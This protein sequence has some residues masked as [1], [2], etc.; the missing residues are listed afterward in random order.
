MFT[1]DGPLPEPQVRMAED[2]RAVLAERS[3]TIKGPAYFMYRDL[4]RSDEDHDWLRNQNLRYD[5][6]VIPSLDLCGEYVKT[7][8]H[9][10]PDNPQGTGY[11][12]IYEILEG[13]AEY[14]L[15][16]K[17]L[18]DAVVVTA[19]KGDVV[20]IPP[21]YGH[22]TINPGIA[23]L[24]MANIV[25]TAFESIY[26]DYEN[27]QGAVYYRME[28]QGY[29]ENARY[30]VHPQL[31]HIR[32]CNVTGFPGIRNRPLYSVIGEENTL[33][34]LNCPEQFRFGDVLTG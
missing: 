4:A 5:V 19:G 13:S 9:Y 2:L 16:D 23:T 34:F 7:K 24:V 18:S 10:H 15:Q 32:K 28:R 14:L 6:T 22:V 12:E 3:C 27:L 33:R 29:V 26:M 11:P 1:W 21:G 20:L 25:S 8:G 30:L 31:R 17:A